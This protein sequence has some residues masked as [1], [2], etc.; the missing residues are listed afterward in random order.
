MHHDDILHAIGNTPLVELK[1]CGPRPEVRLFAKLEGRNPTGSVKDRIVREMV[2]E[3]RNSG[4]LEPGARIIEASTGNTG[5]ALAMV[6]RALG[7]HVRIVIP[8]NVFP[9]IPRTLEAY[10]AEIQW[11]PS[12]LGV[13]R[14]IEVARQVAADEGWYMLDQFSDA[15]NVRS[16]YE[17]TGTEILEDMP[18]VDMFV[19]GLGTGGTLMGVGR[20]L[21]EAN[22]QARV[23]AVE[24]HPGNQVQGLKSLA[25]GFI[26]PLLD[27]GLLD[28]KILVRSGHAFRGAAELMRR[29]AIFGG[30]SS[31][32]VLHGAMKAIERLPRGNVVLLFADS[33]WKYITTQMWTSSPKVHS[34]EDLDDV[35]WW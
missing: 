32:A 25:D 26:P 19:A 33:G 30:V 31:G 10:G 7:H 17:G 9:E 14:A 5:I 1:H 20:R 35:I 29:E 2:L 24:P 13:K 23:I 28:G 6:G 3:A 22:P 27:Y 4:R 12:E 18:Q 8:E 16:H 15:A 21:K 11:V 34:D